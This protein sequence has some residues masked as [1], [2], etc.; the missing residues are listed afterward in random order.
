LEI[1]VSTNDRHPAFAAEIR[2]LIAEEIGEEF[3][4]LL[5]SLATEREKLLTEG[6][7]STYNRKVLRSRTR[8]LIFELKKHKERVP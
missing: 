3:G 4:I 7:L 2:D 5:D 1:S 8:E 6:N